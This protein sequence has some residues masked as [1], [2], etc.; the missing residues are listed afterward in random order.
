MVHF[1]KRSKSSIWEQVPDLP[2]GLEPL[3]MKEARIIE[4]VCNRLLVVLTT[5]S[6]AIP[7]QEMFLDTKYRV[8]VFIRSDTKL[9][10]AL[11]PLNWFGVIDTG[12]FGNSSTLTSIGW[13]EG[14]KM[15]GWKLWVCVAQWP[16][17][18]AKVIFCAFV[19]MA[20]E[21]VSFLT[22]WCCMPL[23]E[24]WCSCRWDSHYDLENVQTE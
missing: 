6:L 21:T 10:Y 18:R 2:E 22:V 24:N 5:N 14:N 16:L 3:L 9:G 20:S 4:D 15:N 1:T 23:H 7:G 19:Y 11:H 17:I 13:I 8:L 12:V